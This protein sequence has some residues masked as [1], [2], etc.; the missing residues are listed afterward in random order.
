MQ[1]RT[2]L[3]GVG[4]A[5]A[6]LA[7]CTTLG[8]TGEGEAG[9]PPGDSGNETPGEGGT[10][11]PGESTP[12]PESNPERNG[13]DSDQPEVDFWEYDPSETAAQRVVGNE[14]A[15]AGENVRP[16][17][18]SIWNAAP[19]ERTLAVH[20]YDDRAGRT[21]MQDAIDLPADTDLQITL[22]EP[23]AYEIE[24]STTGTNTTETVTVGPE[25]FDCNASSTNVAVWPTG[26]VDYRTMTTLALCTDGDELERDG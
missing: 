6:T 20:V 8:E 2:V 4:A 21:R 11:T 24:I 15:T 13:S 25:Y 3:A 23:G 5:V 1:R 16:H 26:S 19:E 12:T 17:V 9:K 22:A 14:S 10:G 7:G 18:V